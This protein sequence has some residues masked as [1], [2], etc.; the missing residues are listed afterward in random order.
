[1]ANENTNRNYTDVAVNREADGNIHGGYVEGFLRRIGL[2]TV[3]TSKGDRLLADVEINVVPTEFAAR[4]LVGEDAAKKAVDPQYGSMNCRVTLWGK[5]AEILGKS[6]LQKSQKVL[7]AFTGAPT[8]RP[9][10][11]RNGVDRISVQLTGYALPKATSRFKEDGELA[12]ATGNTTGAAA[13]A[14]NKAPA[15]APVANMPS[16]GFVDLGDDEELPF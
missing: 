10:T 7:C 9:Y 6:K 11:D 13:P 2:R 14:A 1:M 8:V 15:A 4:Q 5:T 12:L 16:A 3:N